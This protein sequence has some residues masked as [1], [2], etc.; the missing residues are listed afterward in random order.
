MLR[1]VNRDEKGYLINNNYDNRGLNGM[2]YDDVLDRLFPRYTDNNEY[3]RSYNF[4]KA[5]LEDEELY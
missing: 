3:M 4:W 2:A 1:D 5:L